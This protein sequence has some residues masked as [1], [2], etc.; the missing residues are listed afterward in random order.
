MFKKDKSTWTETS[1]TFIP[2]FNGDISGTRISSELVR[3]LTWGFTN[4][5]LTNEHGD[6]K[7]VKAYGDQRKAK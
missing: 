2:P 4:I 1:R 5:E 6:I 7:I 3:E